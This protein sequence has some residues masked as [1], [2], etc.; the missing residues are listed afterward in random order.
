MVVVSEVKMYLRH[1]KLKIFVVFLSKAINTYHTSV[2]YW[3]MLGRG[4]HNRK[5]VMLY[6]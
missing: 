3:H 5:S 1:I 4:M 6:R 2:E